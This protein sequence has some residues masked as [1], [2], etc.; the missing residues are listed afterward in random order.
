MCGPCHSSV[1]KRA[2]CRD[3]PSAGPGRAGAAPAGHGDILPGTGG[4]LPRAPAA[5]RAGGAG[6][7][8]TGPTRVGARGRIAVCGRGGGGGPSACPQVYPAHTRAYP[9]TPPRIPAHTPAAV[10]DSSRRGRGR[11]GSQRAP[12]HRGGDGWR[13]GRSA[14]GWEAE[15]PQAGAKTPVG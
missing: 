7:A 8:A 14:G 13:R 3:E 4:Q 2:R 5:T 9:R 10:G 6:H 12:R 11:E 15:G 1:R